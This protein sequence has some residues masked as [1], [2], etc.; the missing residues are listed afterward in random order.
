LEI[1]DVEFVMTGC[2]VCKVADEDEG[3]LLWIKCEKRKLNFNVRRTSYR[4][5]PNAHPKRWMFISGVSEY[6]ATN[7][8]TCD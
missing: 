7:L 2:G 1:V 6:A 4:G 3:C 8:K 5:L